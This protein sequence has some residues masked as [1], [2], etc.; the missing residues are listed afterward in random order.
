MGTAEIACPGLESLH[1]SGTFNVVSV[2]TQPDRPRGRKLELQP[3]PVKKTALD[4]GIPTLQPKTLRTEESWG[5]LADL[6]PDL[7]VVI[8]FGQILPQCVL[9]L[10]AHGCVNVHTSLLPKFRGA[11]PIQWAIYDGETE[12]GV[13]LM[14]MDAGLDTGPIIARAQTVIGQSNAQELHDDLANLGA[15]L[16]RDALPGYVAGVI[17]P[18][19]QNDAE[20]THARKITKEDGKV[21]WQRTAAEIERAIRA[22]TPWPGAYTSINDPEPVTLKIHKART[23]KGTGN[24]GEVLEGDPGRLLVACGNEALELMELQRPGSRR[25]TAPEFLR[26]LPIRPGSVLE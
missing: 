6:K 24:P 5:V 20:A 2:V 18:T 25:L 15:E 7:I 3:S 4:L 22:F 9:D 10:P 26:G 1:S 19:P 11:A 13:T 12:T 16:L 8:A 23:A 17:S 14:K 21:N